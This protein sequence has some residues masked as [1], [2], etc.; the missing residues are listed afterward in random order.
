MR[1]V[2]SPARWSVF[3]GYD[4]LTREALVS[5]YEAQQCFYDNNLYWHWH[6][7][8]DV[9]S[10]VRYGNHSYTCWLRTCK[11]ANIF[12]RHYNG[13]QHRSS[14]VVSTPMCSVWRVRYKMR[15]FGNTTIWTYNIKYGRIRARARATSV[16]VFTYISYGSGKKQQHAF[17]NLLITSTMLLASGWRDVTGKV[18]VYVGMLSRLVWHWKWC[19]WA[20][21]FWLPRHSKPFETCRG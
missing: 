10:A 17:L 11:H 1:N 6:N 3:N 12:M 16:V 13:S 21:E 2:W 19:I 15:R 14:W 8:V 9:W 5:T 7:A 20:M 18:Y 4:H